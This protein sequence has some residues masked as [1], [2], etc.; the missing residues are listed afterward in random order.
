MI[1]DRRENRVQGS[2]LKVDSRF[3]FCKGCGHHHITHAIDEA[4][5]KLNLDPRNVC[6]T[7]DIGCVGL[8]DSLFESVHTFHTTHGRS[9]AFATGVELADSVLSDSKLKNVVV[10]GDGGAM[11]GLLH[12]VSAAQLNVDV[13]VVLYNNFLFG[14][15]GGQNSS[16]SPMDFITATTPRGNIIPPIDIISVLDGAHGGFLARKTATDDDLAETIAVAINYPGFALVEVLELCTEYALRGNSIRGNKLAEV[17]PGKIMELGVISRRDER[18]DFG[19][20]YRDKFPRRPSETNSRFI[21][22]SASKI[23]N[24]RTGFIIAGTAGERVQFSAHMLVQAAVSCGA[25]ATQKNDNPVT[26]GSGFSIS[27]VVLSG[28]EIYYTG[29]DTP[30]VVI[31]AS[32]EGLAELKAQGVFD[33]TVAG[34]LIVADESLDL[35]NCEGRFLKIPLRRDYTPAGAA[36][37]G[38]LAAVKTTGVLPLEIFKE[39]CAGQKN[40]ASLI[41]MIEKV[42][43]LS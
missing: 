26:Q 2:Y 17:S 39:V 16:F 23:V 40:S 25:N 3:P 20:A 35:P 8:V 28:E 32:Y 34:T 29:I 12:L 11:I 10:I 13:T 36:F 14:M 21:V 4:L 24:K 7:S 42:S 1:S 19:V 38:L 22:P 41:K 5:V 15:T 27:E 30:D 33:R 18:T 37:G 9:T 43:G 6:I 31:V